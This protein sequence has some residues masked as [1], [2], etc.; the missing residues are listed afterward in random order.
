LFDGR[1]RLW[2]GWGEELDESRVGVGM[3]EG[4]CIAEKIIPSVHG[5]VRADQAAADNGGVIQGDGGLD[6]VFVNPGGA[7]TNLHSSRSEEPV[8][9]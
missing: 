5:K 1:G 4:E 8:M 6:H 7:G 2:G 9:D 3:G